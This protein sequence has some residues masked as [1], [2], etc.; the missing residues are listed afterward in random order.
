MIYIFGD[1]Y[2]N[3]VYDSP[4]EV[5]P[6]FERFG[7]TKNFANSGTG[8]QWSF[9]NL[10]DQECHIKPNDII[11]FNNSDYTR[12]NWLDIR[13]IPPYNQ[14][15][16]SYDENLDEVVIHND[17]LDTFDKDYALKFYRTHFYELQESQLKNILYLSFIADKLYCKVFAMSSLP[18]ETDVSSLNRENFYF[19]PINLDSICYSDEYLE[20]V[21]PRKCHFTDHNHDVMYQ[22]FNDFLNGDIKKLEKYA[23]E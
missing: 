9:N 23:W 22:L 18:E 3:D 15:H 5:V 1:S 4:S 17:T 19:F 20:H 14:A 8:P 2:V 16:I 13:D 12:I 7:D 21:D 11:I 10:Y 6:W